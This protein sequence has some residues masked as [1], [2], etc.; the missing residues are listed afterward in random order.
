MNL[1][2]FST[3]NKDIRGEL[4]SF[5]ISVFK[6]FKVK[7]FF[8]INLKKLKLRGNH[9]HKKCHQYLICLDGKVRI[10]CID[11]T[12]KKS[13][14]IS[15]KDN[16]GVFIKAKTWTIIKPLTKSCKILCLCSMQY[17]KSDYI[18]DYLIFQKY[19]LK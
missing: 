4:R 1:S 7:R 15:K 2:S 16:K 8:I 3:I 17:L 10:D 6:K 14:K 12:K 11:K 18:H 19:Y 13:F 9:A 5:D